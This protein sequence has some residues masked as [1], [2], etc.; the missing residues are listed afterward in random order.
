MIEAGDRVLTPDGEGIVMW[1][2][3]AAPDYIHPA[4]FSVRLIDAE[5]KRGYAGTVYAASVVKE[6]PSE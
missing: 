4:A 1:M 3:M 5:N 2:R 6:F